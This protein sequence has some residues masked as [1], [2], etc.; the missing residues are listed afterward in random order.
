MG[1]SSSPRIIDF[2]V[3]K[4]RRDLDRPTL[5]PRRHLPAVGYQCLFASLERAILA[6]RRTGD[7]CG[8]EI[9]ID[10][11]DASTLSGK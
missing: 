8:V 3:A 2:Q 6:G 10:L 9:H 5:S 11:V 7:P 1:L 4:K